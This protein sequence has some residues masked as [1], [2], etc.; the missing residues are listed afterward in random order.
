GD[1]GV[2]DELVEGVLR[3]AA[4][5]ADH[6]AGFGAQP[7]DRDAGGEA[8]LVERLGGLVVAGAAV[9]HGAHGRGGVDLSR[10]RPVAAEV[11]DVAGR[12]V[13]TRAGGGDFGRI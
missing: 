13:A 2:V 10:G 9:D 1:A 8:H 4:L 6:A 7:V 11:V 5:V 12:G 3:G